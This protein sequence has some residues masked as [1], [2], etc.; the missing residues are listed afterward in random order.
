[1][2][3]GCSHMMVCYAQSACPMMRPL[4]GDCGMGWLT[5]TVEPPRRALQQGPSPTPQTGPR[6]LCLAYSASAKG[7][8]WSAWR[9]S[10]GAG[11]GSAACPA[12][13]LLR[14][15]P[16]TASADAAIA[17]AP[18]PELHSQGASACSSDHND[19]GVCAEQCG[20]M[21]TVLRQAQ[22][23]PG[24][25]CRPGS[26]RADSSL[27]CNEAMPVVSGV[28]DA[29][30][31]PFGLSCHIGQEEQPDWQATDSWHRDPVLQP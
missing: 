7:P 29:A 21:Q 9:G 12:A 1:M 16:Q 13:R 15:A 10:G 8:T 4:P 25:C 6:S 23:V 22:A 2:Q 5:R 19:S 26:L 11:G 17:T 28:A 31:T 30:V 27:N 24:Q 3:P 14:P 20:C 18:A